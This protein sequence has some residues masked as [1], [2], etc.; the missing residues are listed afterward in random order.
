M[1][2]KMTLAFV[3]ALAALPRLAEAQMTSRQRVQVLADVLVKLDKPQLQNTD[4]KPTQYIY[5]PDLVEYQYNEYP[6]TVDNRGVRCTKSEPRSVLDETDLQAA[7]VGDDFAAL[8]AKG[9]VISYANIHDAVEQAKTRQRKKRE[10]EAVSR[11]MGSCV[12][13]PDAAKLCPVF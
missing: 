12:K 2:H 3:A 7:N 5:V 1:K 11:A 9:A 10:V 8:E 13:N 6:I 4:C